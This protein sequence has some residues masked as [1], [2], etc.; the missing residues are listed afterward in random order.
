MGD[1]AAGFSANMS[2]GT[3]GVAFS[4]QVSALGASFYSSYSYDG[5]QGNFTAAVGAGTVFGI[6]PAGTTGF[7]GYG[8]NSNLGASVVANT[9]SI[10]GT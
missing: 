4:F 8:W 1:P 10:T 5:D 7:M 2:L 9:T 6:G 3:K